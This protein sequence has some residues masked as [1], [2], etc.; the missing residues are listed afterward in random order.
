MQS[1]VA[2]NKKCL[3][4]IW[5]YLGPTGAIGGRRGYIKGC[6]VKVAQKLFRI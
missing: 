1:T 2:V 4:K 3:G 6:I 5:Q